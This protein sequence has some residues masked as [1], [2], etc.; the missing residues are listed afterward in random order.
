MSEVMDD[1]ELTAIVLQVMADELAAR[2]NDPL[3]SGRDR[4]GHPRPGGSATL[5]A[6]MAEAA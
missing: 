3:I 5:T 6:T 1:R 2:R 4:A